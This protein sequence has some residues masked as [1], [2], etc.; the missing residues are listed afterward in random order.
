M[1]KIRDKLIE[2]QK[3]P[4]PVRFEFSGREFFV[5]IQYFVTQQQFVSKL[6][7]VYSVFA[8]TTDGWDLLIESNFCS[9]SVMQREKNNIDSIGITISELLQAKQVLL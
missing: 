7:D 3:I 4:C 9:E 8:V 1:L 2:I 6:E 5:E